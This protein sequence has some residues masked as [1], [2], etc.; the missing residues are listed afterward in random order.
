MGR[1]FIQYVRTA[2]G[3][4]LKARHVDMALL[5]ASREFVVMNES[6]KRMERREREIK[7]KKTTVEMDE[8][9]T[10]HEKRRKEGRKEECV[11]TG[12]NGALRASSTEQQQQYEQQE[13]T[14]TVYSTTT[15]REK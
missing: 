14:A 13:N 8:S 15:R 9:E 2:L 1:I 12:R 11:R 4:I 7:R 6:R 3:S 5:T 10:A